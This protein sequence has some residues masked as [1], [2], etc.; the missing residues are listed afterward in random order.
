MNDGFTVRDLAAKFR[1]TDPKMIC[2]V[3]DEKYNE[4]Y[5][6]RIEFLC[7]CDNPIE[8][9]IVVDLN[10]DIIEDESYALMI[11]VKEVF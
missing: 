4:L 7:D 9:F 3:E 6:G 11:T 5:R 8:V 10:F 1:Y 2:V